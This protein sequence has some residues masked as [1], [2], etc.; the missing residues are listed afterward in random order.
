MSWNGGQLAW[1]ELILLI[2]VSELWRQF[3]AAYRAEAERGEEVS[4]ELVIAGGDAPEILEPS[5]TARDDAAS[6]GGL[7]GV[8]D[9]L[10]AVGCARD[11]RL[12]F[13]LSEEGAKRI[14]VIIFVGQKFLDAGDQA[15]PF[16]RDDTA[17]GVA[18][19]Q[20]QHPGVEK[21]IGDRVDFASLARQLRFLSSLR[22]E[23][24]ARSSP[25]AHR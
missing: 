11:D 21:F 20:N 22:A 18:R 15:D 5:E 16:L 4:S 13:L 14:R 10:L 6:F 19:R 8:A 1:R 23:T 17:G 3:C 7:P 9:T 24:K 12:D 2:C 25:T